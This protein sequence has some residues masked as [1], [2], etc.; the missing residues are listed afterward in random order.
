MLSALDPTPM[1]PAAAAKAGTAGPRSRLLLLL[2]LVV[3]CLPEEEADWSAEPGRL[4]VDDALAEAGDA[5][6]KSEGALG[7]A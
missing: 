4:E 2:L 5:L 1:K 3:L 7:M 6:S